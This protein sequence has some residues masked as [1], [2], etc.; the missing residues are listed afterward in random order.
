MSEISDEFKI[1][2]VQAISAL[3]KKYPRKHSVMMEHLAKMLRDEGGF[4]YKKAIVECIIAIINESPDSKEIGLMQL[5]EFI[6]DCEHTS[7]ATRVLHLLGQHGPSC[8]NP[9]KYIRFIYNRVI[10]ENEIVRAAAVAA[11]AKFGAVPALTDSVLT[12]MHRAM[13]DEDDEVRDRATLYYN[14]LK[15]KNTKLNSAY[16]LNELPVSLT[17]LERQLDAYLHTSCEEAFN[18]KSVPVT[19]MVAEETPKAKAAAKTISQQE[20]YV[21]ELSRIPAFD[22][23]GP[24]FK[25][26]DPVKLTENETEYQVTVIKHCFQSHVLLQF[27]CENTLNDQVLHNLTIEVEGAE[28]YDPVSYLPCDKLPYQTPGKAYTVLEYPEDITSSTLS[29]TMKF[30]VHDCDPN[31]GDEDEQGFPD[32]YVIDDIEITIGDFIQKIIKSNFAAAWEEVG[33]E[34]EVENTYGKITTII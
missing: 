15:E 21:E 28:G 31:T 32:E 30:E 18:M 22:S 2:V 10:L 3:C 11:L 14:I 27:N 1:V 6:E 29:C 26:S 20:L 23:L 17:A 13:I 24:L 16:I 33:D 19:S 12:L 5:C 7:L 25:S 4:E 34:H 9:A 8:E